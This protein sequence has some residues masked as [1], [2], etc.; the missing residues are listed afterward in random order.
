MADKKKKS[1]R[2]EVNTF[3]GLVI[4]LIFLLVMV[5]IILGN[6]DYIRKLLP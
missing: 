3:A 1:G 4:V 5:S 2:L 6:K